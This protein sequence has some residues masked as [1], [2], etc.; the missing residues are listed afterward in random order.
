MNVLSE[1]AAQIVM[2]KRENRESLKENLIILDLP[3]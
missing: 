3:I 1:T 2:K